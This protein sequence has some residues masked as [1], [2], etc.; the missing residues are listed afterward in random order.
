MQEAVA[1]IVGTVTDL[2]LGEAALLLA[3][4]MAELET[5][6]LERHQISMWEYVVLGRLFAT[7]AP[8]QAELAR[9][10]GRDQTRLITHL[11]RL[12]SVGLLTRRQD[13]ADR[14]Q[15]IV[16]MTPQGR[17]LFTDCRDEIR[18]MEATLLADLPGRGAAFRRHLERLATAPR[19][20]A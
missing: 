1:A 11:D 15:R 2:D 14:R 18:R 13:P 10:S 9:R 7:G 8:T 4:R 12:E 20:Q 16:E 5:P 6:I 3:R 17:V 19:E